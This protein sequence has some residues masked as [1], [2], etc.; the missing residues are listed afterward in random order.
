MID[1]VLSDIED[2]EGGLKE[3]EVIFRERLDSNI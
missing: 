3:F 2:N 1:R